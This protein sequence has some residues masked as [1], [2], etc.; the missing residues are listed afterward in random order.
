MVCFSSFFLPLS[1]FP[2]FF[3]FFSSFFFFFSSFF[4]FF[5][6]LLLQSTFNHGAFLSFSLSLSLSVSPFSLFSHYNRQSLPNPSPALH[7]HRH[8][9]TNNRLAIRALPASGRRLHLEILKVLLT[10]HGGTARTAMPSQHA[11]TE[12]PRPLPERRGQ[13]HASIHSSCCPSREHSW[14]VRASQIPP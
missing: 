5:S 1:S 9:P 4:F 13:R 14:T 6:F 7:P 12:V 11:T 2:F 8:H 3:F 10:V